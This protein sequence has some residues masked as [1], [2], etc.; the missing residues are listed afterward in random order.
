MAT[1]A[2]NLEVVTTEVPELKN[3]RYTVGHIRDWR[4]HEPATSITLKGNW[5]NDAGFVTGTPLKIRVMPGCLVLTA[6][7]PLPAPPPEPEIMQTL[8]KVCKLS[9]RKQQQILEFI[10]VISAKWPPAGKWG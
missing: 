6:Q 1:H 3:R 4:T 5:L 9:G 2:T 10:G 7:E 8:K